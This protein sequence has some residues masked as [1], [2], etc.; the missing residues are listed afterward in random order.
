[1]SG[2]AFGIRTA[3]RILAFFLPGILNDYIYSIILAKSSMVLSN[4]PAPQSKLSISGAK[5]DFFTFWPPQ[6]DNIGLCVSLTSYNGTVRVGVGSDHAILENPKELVNKLDD[7][8]ES[9]SKMVGV[10]DL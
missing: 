1:M 3:Q 7:L 10:P 5:I 2:D 9:L 8:V 4:V 6:I